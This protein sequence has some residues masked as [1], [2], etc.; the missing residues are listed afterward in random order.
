MP[1][2]LVC[3]TYAAVTVGEQLLSPLFPTARAELGMTK[4]QGG[5]AF[6]VLAA[7][8]AVF[9]MVAGLAL[10]RW[11]AS[12]VMRASLAVTVAGAVLAALATGLGTIVAA[13]ALL[14]A[15]AGLFFPSGLQGVAAFGGTARRGFAMGLYGV[16]FSAGLTIAALFG[17]LGASAGWRVPFWITAGLAVAALAA[18]LTLHTAPPDPSVPRTIPWRAVLGLPTLVGT[19]G[20]TLQ[21]G[22]LAFF[23]TFA[24]DQW[25]LSEARAALVLAIGRVISIIAKVLGGQATDRRGARASVFRTGLLL[26]ALGAVW[27]LAPANLATYAVAAVFAGT[28]SSIFPAANVMAVERFGGHGLAL[29]AYR[30]VQIGIGALA[31]LLIGR[32]PLGLRWTM[33]AAVLTSVLLVWWCRPLPAATRAPDAPSADAHTPSAAP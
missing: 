19:V 22:V 6:A 15:G 2:A 5:V 23:T 12:A 8:I 26:S 21:Y 1:F 3:A 20:A 14:G 13:Q 4:A 28:V 9:N 10:R 27:V 17:S 18:M 32:S 24:V 31:G 33:F 16:A 25:K 11:R 7:S 30:S 29:G